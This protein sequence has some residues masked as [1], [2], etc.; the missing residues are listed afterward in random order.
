M[1]VLINR[2]FDETTPESAANGEWSNSGFIAENE[3]CTFREL[4]AH[5]KSHRECSCGPAS[6]D[7]NAWFSSGFEIE[8][9]GTMTERQT[10]IHLSRDN[11]E[12]ALRYWRLA[13]IVAGN[14]KAI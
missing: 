1:T 14:I 3:V 6:A 5:M 8:D 2:T 13:A 4:V 11:K 12:H 7:W 10:S 9:Y